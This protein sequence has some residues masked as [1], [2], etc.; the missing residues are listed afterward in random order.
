MKIDTV[1][2]IRACRLSSLG[3]FSSLR[4]IMGWYKFKKAYPYCMTLLV[5][6]YR[7]VLFFLQGVPIKMRHLFSFI[8]PYILMLQFYALYGQWKDVLMFVLH[9]GT[10][11]RD[12]WFQRY[13]VSG[14][15]YQ[16]LCQTILKVQIYWRIY[17]Y[18]R[19]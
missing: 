17:R 15:V 18:M 10:G 2:Q 3:A 13:S 4:D 19:F 8:S 6:C 5:K 9:I 12:K 16:I 1:D 7:S 14:F 11:L